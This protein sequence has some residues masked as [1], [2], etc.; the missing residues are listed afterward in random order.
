[1]DAKGLFSSTPEFLRGISCESE[2][3]PA[4]SPLPSPSVPSLLDLVLRRFT[5]DALLEID[6]GTL[7][8]LPEGLWVE[9]VKRFGDAPLSLRHLER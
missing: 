8:T 1:M 3:S 9:V 2:D 7:D 4:I 5:P 6:E